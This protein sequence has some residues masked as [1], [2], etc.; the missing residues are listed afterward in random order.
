LFFLILIETIGINADEDKINAHVNKI[1][2]KM[3]AKMTKDHFSWFS[4]S[5]V[6]INVRNLLVIIPKD[7][8]V[9]EDG[10]QLN[11]EFRATTKQLSFTNDVSWDVPKYLAPGLAT[12]PRSEFLSFAMDMSKPATFFRVRNFFYKYFFFYNILN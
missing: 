3:K 1:F 7:Y 6:Q 11:L 5:H 9:R 4:Q 8:F 10:I 2:E 12:I